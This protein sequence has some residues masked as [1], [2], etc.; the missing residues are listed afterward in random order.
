MDR[1]VNL[2]LLSGTD[3]HSQTRLLEYR[4]RF[5]VQQDFNRSYITREI[6]DSYQKGLTTLVHARRATACMCVIRQFCQYLDGSD[7]QNYLPG[8]LKMLRSH[9]A[10]QPYIYNSGQIR[11]LM[12]AAARLL[13]LGSLKLSTG[14]QQQI[15]NQ[16]I[17]LKKAGRLIMR[18]LK[19][20]G[21]IQQRL[22]NG[23]NPSL[24]AEEKL[25][26]LKSAAAPDRQLP[27]TDT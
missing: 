5:L 16:A 23:I 7:P 18:F 22:V 13:P 10:R 8:L 12:A 17:R 15:R 25:F 1:F 6:T 21:F 27:H 3:Y 19:S 20:Q 14:A 4:D 26:R 11:A 24:T 9:Q 2:R